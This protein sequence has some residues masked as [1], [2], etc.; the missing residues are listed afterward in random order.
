MRNA[1]LI[2]VLLLL[3]CPPPVQAPENIEDMMN[4]GFIYFD[5]KPT[6]IHSLN[7]NLMPFL[8]ENADQAADGWSVHSLSTEDLEAAGVE[9]K[10]VSNIIGAAAM[11]TYHLDLDTTARGVTWP[12]KTETIDTVLEFRVLEESE[13]RACFLS[14]ECTRYDVVAEQRTQLPLSIVATQTY[15]TQYRWILSYENLEIL[16]IRGLTPDGI[17]FDSDI[18]EVLQQYSFAVIFQEGKVTRRMEAFW[19]DG[20][21]LGSSVQEGYAVNQA[22]NTMH[23]NAGQ[24]EDFFLNGDGS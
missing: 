10:D 7:D 5:D 3:G 18:I 8:R 14:K 22:I 19:V 24:I 16:L 9:D 15:T 17:A 4:F 12:D 1:I 13:D 20:R 2:P 23:R 21:L 6:Y 11:A